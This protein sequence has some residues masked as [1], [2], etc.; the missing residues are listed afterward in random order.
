VAVDGRDGDAGE[1]EDPTEQPVDVGDE[2]RRLGARA[3]QP[4][5]VEPV[6]IELAFTGRDERNRPVDGLDAIER[7]VQ[8][9]DRLEIEAVLA[10]A[11]RHDPHIA[12]L[13]ELDHRGDG[14]RAAR[15]R[16]VCRE[17]PSI[18]S[19]AKVEEGA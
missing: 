10:V 3:Q 1:P 16:F 4:V 2:R 12:V 7:V 18:R 17:R 14:N 8:R 11:H 9:G 19:S 15:P 13:L 6:R 5:E